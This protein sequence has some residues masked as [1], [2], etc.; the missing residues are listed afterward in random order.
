ML[1]AFSVTLIFGAGLFISSS[2]SLNCEGFL[3]QLQ[4]APV[5]RAHVSVSEQS[6]PM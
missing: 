5:L 4:R 6:Y 1:G 3:R 2:S